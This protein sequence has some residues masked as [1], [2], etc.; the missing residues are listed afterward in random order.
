MSITKEIVDEY[1]AIVLRNQ[2]GEALTEQENQRYLELVNEII[3]PAY[4]CD[5][6]L[7][8]KVQRIIECK[9]TLVANI[10]VYELLKKQL[11]AE[12]DLF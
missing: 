2:R 1:T 10:A 3:M 6:T 5:P 8:Q 4:K 12:L 9:R 7:P 11:I